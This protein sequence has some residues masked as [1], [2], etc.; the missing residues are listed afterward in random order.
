MSPPM[1]AIYI[2]ALAFGPVTAL[3]FLSRLISAHKKKNMDAE[4]REIKRKH[5]EQI[6]A[7]EDSLRRNSK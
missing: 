7:Y 1:E 3:L 2:V 6:Q 5:E 4:L